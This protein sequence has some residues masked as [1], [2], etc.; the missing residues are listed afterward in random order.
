MIVEVITNAHAA[1]GRTGTKKRLGAASSQ[2]A[3]MSSVMEIILSPRMLIM[4][5]HEAW[6]KAATRTAKVIVAVMKA[7]AAGLLMA[8]WTG[9]VQRRVPLFRVGH[10]PFRAA[11]RADQRQAF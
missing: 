5:F 11:F 8:A 10:R 2:Q 9:A 1:S 4:A 6:H 7:I 3:P